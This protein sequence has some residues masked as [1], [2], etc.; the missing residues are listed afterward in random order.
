MPEPLA[1]SWPAHRHPETIG[2]YKIVSKI[3][4]GAMG[5]VYRA[6]DPLIGREVAIKIL[7]PALDGAPDSRRRFLREAR[8]AG[9]LSHKNIITIYD[10]VEDGDLTY[11]IMELLEGEDLQ[12]WIARRPDLPLEHTLET[13][14]E[15]C[16]GLAHAHHKGIIHRDIKPANIFITRFD[17][18]KIL[19][20]GLAHA[21]VS[22]ITQTGYVMGTPNY[23]SPE[24]ARGEKADE[25]SDLFSLGAVFYELL[26]YAKPFAAPSL[27]ATIF[28][29]LQAEPKPIDD[30]DARLPRELG[31][32]V[33]KALAKDPAARFQRVG[34]LRRDLEAVRRTIETA[35]ERLIEETR[36]LSEQL[37]QLLREN[38]GLLEDEW[39]RRGEALRAANRT[40]VPGTTLETA[41]T[42][43]A[44]PD[45]LK[46]AV[47]RESVKSENERLGVL[48]QQRKET[49]A[50]LAEAQ[51]L[52]KAGQR[53]SALGLAEEVLLALPFHQEAEALVARLR[54]ALARKA[55]DEEAASQASAQVEEARRHEE[56]GRLVPA[57]EAAQRAL[58]LVPGHALATVLIQELTRRRDAQQRLQE[59]QERREKAQ[60]EERA[61]RLEA[62]VLA[63]RQ[64]LASGDLVAARR[65]TQALDPSSPS[66]PPL[67]EELARCEAAARDQEL[68]IAAA[69]DRARTAQ[70]AGRLD[71]ALSLA[72]SVAG[73]VADHEGARRLLTELEAARKGEALVSEAAGHASRGDL[74]AAISLLERADTS[75]PGIKPALSLHRTADRARKEA[76]RQSRER[77]AVAAPAPTTVMVARPAVVEP[78]IAVPRRPPAPSPTRGSKMPRALI[79]AAAGALVLTGLVLV[80]RLVW[81]SPAP[82]PTASKEA[83]A[84]SSSIGA[85]A[86]PSQAPAESL[87]PVTEARSPSG[88]AT[89]AGGTDPT[90]GQARA[91]GLALT[92]SG[93]F[94]E[95]ATLVDEALKAFPK[96]AGLRQLQAEV[97]KRSR[98]AAEDAVSKTAEARSLAQQARAAD[99]AAARLD[100]ARQ[101][102][103]E[104]LRLLQAHQTGRAVAK[105]GE[106]ADNYRQAEADARTEATRRAES[107]RQRAAPTATAPTPDP[108]QL[109]AQR[110]VE[111]ARRA[112]ES[113]KRGVGAQNPRAAAEEASAQELLHQGRLPDAEAAYRRAAALLEAG[114]RAELDQQAVLAVL[115]RYR[116]AVESRDPAAIKA[117]WP[118]MSAAQEK[119][120][121]A[122]FEF[123]RSHRVELRSPEVEVDGDTASLRCQRHDEMVTVDGKQAQTDLVSTFALRRKGGAWEI[124]A[125]R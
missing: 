125:I 50:R 65:L 35:K 120:I 29:I 67:L 39:V 12:A 43:T 54:G 122:S 16:E 5:E 72:R 45:Y 81:W 53:E 38:R 92:E 34:D 22:D 107:D 83:V 52:E 82:T 70:A 20:F 98:R 24:Q 23:M 8:S 90:P 118:S 95:A 44:P 63:A 68:R 1:Q 3:G 48:V 117:V 60:A 80:A 110:Q 109:L 17:Q 102:E 96:D 64:A 77:A 51:R 40:L 89:P 25:R 91:R 113:A 2:K 105:L 7:S 42:I 99:L 114:R 111:E 115:Q 14:I 104:G 79:G 47:L 32:I 75:L 112:L 123:E 116:T 76:E 31:A 100:A 62:A 26:T 15:V 30:I 49:A 87:P 108:A 103:A 86:P 27:P 33:A 9:Q 69:L 6:L 55:R 94:E 61:R 13:M 57:L 37:D 41:D 85:V 106:A 84:A 56:A 46:A 124:E 101:T 21:G 74:G 88:V 78:S 58:A 28:K 93:R 71:E 121:K 66:V 10:L 97:A 73:E 119:R 11:L 59:E 19:D 18:V 36:G 4:A